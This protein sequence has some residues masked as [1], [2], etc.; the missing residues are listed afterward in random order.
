MAQLGS[1]EFDLEF[2]IEEFDFEDAFLAD[3]IAAAPDE[4]TSGGPVQRTVQAPVTPSPLGLAAR[5]DAELEANPLGHEWVAQA[6]ISIDFKTAKRAAFR[7]SFRI[8]KHDA[9]LKI[10]ALEVMCHVCRRTFDAVQAMDAEEIERV[11][12]LNVGLADD[13]PDREQPDLN[14][15]GQIDNSHLIGGDLS[16]RAKRIIH[17]PKGTIIRHVIDRRGMNGYSATKPK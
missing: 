10:D 15:P 6:T 11:A 7:N 9:G 8:S 16:V 17:E 4:P 5:V 3:I 2:P 13:D 14:C 12:A 1:T